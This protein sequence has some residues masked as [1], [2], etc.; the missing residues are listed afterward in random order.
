[1]LGL[2]KPSKTLSNVRTLHFTSQANLSSLVIASA[3][4]VQENYLEGR[5][6]KIQIPW[7]S[8]GN[9]CFNRQ[10]REFAFLISSPAMLINPLDQGL[11]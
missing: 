11:L 7:H 4:S 8:V 1:M 6:F 5:F 10:S 9:K 3:L 2:G